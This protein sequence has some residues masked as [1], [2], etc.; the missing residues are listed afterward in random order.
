[1]V[2]RFS[3]HEKQKNKFSEKSLID[4]LDQHAGELRDDDINCND[5]DSIL[6]YF[7]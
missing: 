4:F 3:K 2:Q 7:L 5:L 6:V 1:M